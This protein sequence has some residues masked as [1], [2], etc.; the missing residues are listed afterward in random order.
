MAP[1]P[2]I[3]TTVAGL[4]LHVPAQGPDPGVRPP[5]KQVEHGKMRA[6]SAPIDGSEGEQ[7]TPEPARPASRQMVEIGR[8]MIANIVNDTTDMRGST[9]VGEGSVFTD[10]DNF[11]R[12]REVLFR[13]TPQVMAWAG[14]VADPG[15]VVARDVAGVPVLVARDYDGEVRA[16]LNACSHRGMT[17]CDGVD[18]TRRLTCPYHGWNYDLQGNLVG[19]PNRDRFPELDIGRLG[20]SPLPVSVQKG[21][22]VVGLRPDV[23]VDGFLDDLGDNYDWL[24][25]DRYRAGSERRFEKKANWKLMIDLNNEAY[26]VPF[27]HRESLLPFLADHCTVDTFGP[28]SRMCVPFKGIERF[29]DVP[30]TEW[31]ERL[32]TI[33]VSCIFP[34]TVVIDHMSG[35]SMHRVS[36]GARPGESRLHMIEASPGVMDAA[37][38]AACE[39]VMQVNLQ[40]LDQED[41]VAT[42]A[43]QR[44]YDG[45]ARS[46]VGGIGEALIGH[47]HSVWAAAVRDGLSSDG[48]AART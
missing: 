14:E 35:G 28:H 20:L 3:V 11:E 48:V 9:F 13:R 34:A 8:R 47:W 24:G 1:R 27:L 7:R 39:D 41:Y 18:N 2:R 17:L 37:A 22:V 31:P 21:L 23:V 6:M 29:A 19:L 30:E 32:D 26:H 5:G 44:G 25:Y 36:P 4:A 15:D 10:P 33:M 45:G 46:L 38:S 12:E 40:I 42:E 43:C 16:F